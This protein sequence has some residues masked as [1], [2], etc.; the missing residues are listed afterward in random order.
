MIVFVMMLL[1]VVL[2][3]VGLAVDV[4]I[5]YVVKDKMQTAV[6]GA[7]L[8][9]ARSLNRGQDFASQQANATATAK[10]IYHM[11]MES[12]FL[13]AQSDGDP[14]ITFP[15]GPPQSMTVR[16]A[17]QVTA[18]TYFLRVIGKDS[19]TMGS[20]AQA[21][22]RYVNIMMVIDRSGS[23]GASCAALRAASTDFAKAFVNGRDKLGL[24]TFGTSYRTDFAIDDEFLSASPG[25]PSLISNLACVGGTNAAAA[26]WQAYQQIQALNEPG[27][28]NV[29]LFFTD[30]LPNTVHLSNLEIKSSS[31]CSDKSAK[32]GVLAA[33]TGSW[34]G[35]LFVGSQTLPPGAGISP[36]VTLISGSNNCYFR[37]S[38]YTYVDYDVAA[39]TRTGQPEVDIM[40]NSL[41]GWKSVTRDGSGRIQVTNANVTNT[42]INAMVSAATRVRSDTSLNVITYAIGLGSSV[43]SD[44]LERV[45]NVPGTA[46]Y[47]STKPPGKFIYASDAS[48]LQSAFTQLASDV[49]RMS[50]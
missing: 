48:K 34:A 8:A 1:F 29:I 4:G 2:P 31:T 33:T 9:A 45:A 6:D 14:T 13:G 22:R 18:P 46:F 32:S 41:T 21:T 28:L 47:D 40:G 17:A 42:G 3:A 10:K 50:E 37:N 5:L 36:D 15:A 24:V 20:V 30:G 35:G 38:G 43:D 16:V 19:V 12:G 27:A 49:L 39:L 44:L 23:L 7:S 11:N 25:V 26:Y